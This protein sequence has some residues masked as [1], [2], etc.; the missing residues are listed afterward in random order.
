[1]K[2][3]FIETLLKKGSLMATVLLSAAVILLS[4]DAY[5]RNAGGF[6]GP[7]PDLVTVKEALSMGDDA[8][9]SLKGNIVKN[10]GDEEYTFQDAT[11]TIEVEIDDDIWRG[12]TVGP[13]DVV[14]ISG[15]V[16][17]DWRS[18]TIDV[19]SLSVASPAKQ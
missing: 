5:A 14:I 2:T 6:N 8:R 9:V 16:D 7:G 15:E 1:M 10:L 12:R 4:G 18:T 17:K 11:G 3:V 19:S 13:E